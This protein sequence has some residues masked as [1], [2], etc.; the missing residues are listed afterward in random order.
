MKNKLLILPFA[1]LLLLGAAIV[2]CGG[3]DDGGTDAG[4]DATEQ[5]AGDN[6]DNGDN[7]GGFFEGGSATLTIGDETWEFDGIFCAFS[8]E[9]S[10]NASISF[11]LT[12]FGEAE[13]GNRTQ[14]DVSIFDREDEGRYEGDGVIQS[15]T[16]DDIDDFQNPTIGWDAS[17]GFAGMG[18]PFL[19]IDGKNVRA[20]T[21]FDNTLTDE[22]IEEI[23]GTFEAT[24]P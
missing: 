6:G 21:V 3:D 5:P 8:P 12:S 13:S 7:G 19:E 1:L 2:A 14:L 22:E 24:C 23:P 4:P 9:E 10:Q 15:I 16:L 11:T 18:E 17:S 20:E